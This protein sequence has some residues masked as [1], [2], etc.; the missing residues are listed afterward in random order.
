MKKQ[1]KKTKEEEQQ[2]TKNMPFSEILQKYPGTAKI[3]FEHGMS[4]MGCPMAM[5]ETIEQGCLAHGIDPD[6]IVAEINKAVK[7]KK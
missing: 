7:K 5:S 4:C 2:I 1:I 3:F 6:K